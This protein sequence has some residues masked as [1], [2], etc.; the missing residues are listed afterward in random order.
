MAHTGSRP[1]Y[2]P[3]PAEIAEACR[4]IQERNAVESRDPESVEDQDYEDEFWDQYWDDHDT[5]V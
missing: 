4:Q 3:T 2:T 5:R 1:N